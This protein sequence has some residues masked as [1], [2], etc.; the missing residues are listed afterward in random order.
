MASESSVEKSVFGKMDDGREIETFTL[1]N[2]QGTTAKLISY[3]A[4]LQSLWLPDKSNTFSDVVL[5]FDDLKGYTGSHPFF[6]GTIGR[7]ANRIAKG[8]FTLDGR[9]YTLPLNDGDNT[10]HGGEEGFH[11]KVWKGQLAK[12]KSGAS[13]QFAYVSP[14]GEEGFPGTLEATVVYT[15]TEENEL[16]I[17]CRATTDKATPVNLT[18]HSYFNLAGSGDILKHVLQLNAKQ[19]TPVNSALIPTGVVAPVKATPFDFLQPTAIGARI[20]EIAGDPA[21]YDHNFVLHGEKGKLGLVARLSD[22]AS[23]R[24][25]EVWTTQPGIQFYSGNYLDGTLRGKRGVFYL[26]HAALCL[27]TQH[28]PDSV[29]HPAFPTTILRPGSVFCEQTVFR[30]SANQI[31]SN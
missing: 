11:R 29:N 12:E 8:K 17:D 3:G 2:A 22:P 30:F 28:Y 27:E 10:L 5:G 15:L 23:N 25:M 4:A 19:Y 1:K 21:G 24:Q 13:V 14:D 31:A 6:G 7:F 18:N 9:E 20:G 26:K 16:K